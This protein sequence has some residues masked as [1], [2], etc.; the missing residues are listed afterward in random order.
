MEDDVN[1]V[2]VIYIMI[3]IIVI[4][5]IINS[6]IQIASFS[7]V[8]ITSGY[9]LVDRWL[10]SFLDRCVYV[11][12]FSMRASAHR[13]TRL[14]THTHRVRQSGRRLNDFYDAL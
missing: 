11:V 6:Y 3:N 5:V 7:V 8:N 10:Q 9:I 2:I 12:R 1:L 4:V 13:R 14:D